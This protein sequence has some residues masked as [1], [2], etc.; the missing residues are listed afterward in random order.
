MHLSQIKAYLQASNCVHM[1]H[2]GGPT[3]GPDPANFVCGQ[4]PHL[5]AQNQGECNAWRL[6]SRYNSPF[7]LQPSPNGLRTLA[8]GHILLTLQSPSYQP[9]Q[10][11]EKEMWDG[12]TMQFRGYRLLFTT[13]MCPATF[14]AKVLSLLEDL[15]LR[16]AHALWVEQLAFWKAYLPT[17]TFKS[18]HQL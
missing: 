2:H 12:T 18:V 5:R 4:I 10:R 14:P 9:L 7:P 6:T 16:S 3:G 1:S 17:S 8:N 15:Q 13:T 11:I